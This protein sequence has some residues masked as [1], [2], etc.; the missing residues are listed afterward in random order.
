[1]DL[2]EL[3]DRHQVSL[4]RAATAA[5]GPSRASHRALAAGYARRI[6]GM[7]R[8]SGARTAPLGGAR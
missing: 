5:C 7:R 4:M 3:L 2:N 8:D 1:M 6:D